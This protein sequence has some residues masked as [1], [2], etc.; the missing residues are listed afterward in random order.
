MHRLL[1]EKYRPFLATRP[2][3]SV[4]SRNF[5]DIPTKVDYL[6]ALLFPYDSDAPQLIW[7]EIKVAD[8]IPD[9]YWDGVLHV[10]PPL[11][12]HAVVS[13]NET[14][15]R[16][17]FTLDPFVLREEL[18][19]KRRHNTLRH[20]D[21]MYHHFFPFDK[22]QAKQGNRCLENLRAGYSYTG[23]V[24]SWQPS[25]KNGDQIVVLE[26]VR[27]GP[28]NK[29]YYPSITLS[30]LRWSFEE[31]SGPKNTLLASKPN[32]YNL[33]QSND[34]VRAVRVSS[35]YEVEVEDINEFQEIKVA[36]DHVIFSE[37]NNVCPMAH[38]LG[39]SL[40]IR[41]TSSS[42]TIGE[43]T[44]NETNEHWLGKGQLALITEM[45]IKSK[46]WGGVNCAKWE[47]G[48]DQSF[49]V[50]REDKEGITAQQVESLVQYYQEV[51]S[52]EIKKMK[53]GSKAQ[54]GKEVR[55]NQ[56]ARKKFVEDYLMPEQFCKFFEELKQK[57]LLEG[58]KSWANAVPPLPREFVKPEPERLATAQG[59]GNSGEE[60]G[61]GKQSN[62]KET[63]KATK[64]LG[65]ASSPTEKALQLVESITTSE[66]LGKG[67]E[68]GQVRGGPAEGK[69]RG[70]KAKRKRD[71]Y[72]VDTD[73]SE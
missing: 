42:Q 48:Q 72:E 69:K 38:Q 47:T 23:S 73:K 6:L 27:W 64:P 11:S 58:D 55:P 17:R 10:L 30:D 57:K 29:Q 51:L 41:E 63:L 40:C 39:F 50:A 35:L 49:I 32:P 8:K 9:Q 46:H 70:R 53:K 14:L 20:K 37:F 31:I 60:A 54:P 59:E 15:R 62:P 21:K 28:E 4:V 34:W 52:A 2:G 43:A 68:D 36:P 56:A 33:R 71:N 61:L 24:R 1:C 66:D 13:S 45:N 26:S 16:I 12:A 3:R 19:K 22:D 5:W 44:E 25:E 67:K 65:K 7:L 18:P